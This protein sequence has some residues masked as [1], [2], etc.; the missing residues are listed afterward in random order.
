[1]A[2][3]AERVWQHTF[4]VCDKSAATVRDVVPMQSWVKV[5]RAGE[6][7]WCKVLSASNGMFTVAVDN[8]LVGSHGINYG[9]SLTVQHAHVL[10]VANVSD[11]LDFTHMVA[12]HGSTV[13]GALAWRQQRAESGA[14]LNSNGRPLFVLS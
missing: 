1:M 9:D 3:A 10:E 11:M 8:H 6:R 12:E 5:G 4:E 2:S 14:G 13:K 7:F